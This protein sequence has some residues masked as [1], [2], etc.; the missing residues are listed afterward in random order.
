[1]CFFSNV[2]MSSDD[3]IEILKESQL[4][5]SHS[6]SFSCRP[7]SP[8]GM[9]ECSRCEHILFFPWDQ[10][11]LLVGDV[12][13]VKN[14]GCLLTYSVYLCKDQNSMVVCALGTKQGQFVSPKHR[15]GNR[16]NSLVLLTCYILAL[17]F[18]QYGTLDLALGQMSPLVISVLFMSFLFHWIVYAVPFVS[19]TLWLNV[20]KV[21]KSTKQ[22]TTT[23][24]EWGGTLRIYSSGTK[25]T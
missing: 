23:Y 19:V 24:A 15:K 7:S 1:M 12:Y 2:K 6:L 21:L 14:E 4:Q 22:L 8:E 25:T 17:M 10:R 13:H 20:L 3:L 5:F 11:G 18:L 9:C 16:Q